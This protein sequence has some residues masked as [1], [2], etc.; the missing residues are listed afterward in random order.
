MILV[1]DLRSVW[2]SLPC[3]IFVSRILPKDVTFEQNLE[4]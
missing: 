1:F 3:A 4:R 2:F